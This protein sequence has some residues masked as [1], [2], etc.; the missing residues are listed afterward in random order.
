MLLISQTDKKSKM[1]DAIKMFY[2]QAFKDS[3]YFKLS[4]S[5]FFSVSFFPVANQLYAIKNKMYLCIF[6]VVFKT[7]LQFSIFDIF[8]INSFYLQKVIL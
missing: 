2:I 1:D 8:V 3:F 4:F 7:R 6:V 5:F